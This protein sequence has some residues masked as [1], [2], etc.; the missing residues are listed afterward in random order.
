MF[1]IEEL[2]FYNYANESYTYKFS[3]GI[4]Y[5]K[6]KNNSGK[7]VFYTLLDYILGSSKEIKEDWYKNISEISMKI[8]NNDITYTLVRTKDKDVNYLTVGKIDF[9]S[10]YPITYRE[11]KL[12]LENIF[13]PENSVL[14]EIKTFTGED[15]TFRTFTMFNFLGE[16]KQGK[17][18]DFLD[19]CSEVEYLV[20]LS[21]LL[22]FIFNK[23]L[24]R[25]FLLEEELKQLEKDIKK[26]E[27]QKN[28]YEFINKEIN[29]NITILGLNIQYN[30]RNTDLIKE[31]L[32]L[33]KQMNKQNTTTDASSNISELSL[34]LENIDEQIKVYQNYKKEIKNIE[35]ENR[36]RKHLLNTLDEILKKNNQYEYL[37]SPVSKLLSELDKTISFSQ[38]TI[39]DKTLDS[40]KKQRELLKEEIKKNNAKFKRFSLKEKEKAIILLEDYL[41][42]N[43]LYSE[44][45]FQAKLQ[46]A[47]AIRDELKDLKNQ[48]NQS[49][50]NEL[51]K[52]I[53]NLYNSAKEVSSF[54]KIDT[55]KNEFR[56][57][58]IKKGNILQPMIKETRFNKEKNTNDEILV[59]YYT[60]SMARHTLI[61]ICGYFGFLKLLLSENKYPVIPIFVGDHL[62]K[63]YDD[64]NVNALGTIINNAIN[65]IGR[66]NL[67]IFL[68]D[69]ED[70]AKL[71]LQPDY[72]ENLIV[73]DDNGEI[74]KSGFLPF[75]QPDK[76]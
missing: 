3:T 35:K 21:S 11:Y 34:M 63:P 29:N 24:K 9:E 33:Y 22:N 8:C 58:Y 20:K 64:T 26:I 74:V 67:Q 38:N 71:T 14:E 25:I 31:R 51:S 59:N 50:I 55:D 57:Q 43:L 1:K 62:S 28:Q 61:Q 27:M 47:K 2:T 53:T 13:T 6:G 5:F 37:L 45:E 56:I 73:K 7:T 66:E 52:Y 23:N 18:Q 54:V 65:E 4:N 36:N 19:K 39:N 41:S 70:F 42:K 10:R 12:K 75:Y 17:I 15:L 76:K 30:G 16:K 68:F 49:K 60:G 46:R 40:L 32:E 48:D 44:E 69:D 72:S